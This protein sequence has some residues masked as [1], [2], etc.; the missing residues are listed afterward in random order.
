MGRTIAVPAMLALLLP[1][2]V[3]VSEMGAEDQQPDVLWSQRVGFSPSTSKS[4]T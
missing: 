4:A 1:A 2:L 3:V